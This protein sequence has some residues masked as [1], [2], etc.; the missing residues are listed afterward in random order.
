MALLWVPFRN[1]RSDVIVALALVVVM[2]ASGARRRRAAVIGA[3]AGAAIAF[4]FFDTE[5]YERFAMVKQSDVATAIALVVVGLL[6]GE[7][8]I[9]LARSRQIEGAATVDLGRVREAA[10]LLASGAEVA[11]FIG[12]VAANL[13]AVLDAD[14][15]AF[16]AEPLAATTP[17]ADRLG[18]LTPPPA[19]GP[20]TEIALPVWALGEVV[21]HFVMRAAA[22][23]TSPERLQVAMTLADQVGAALAAQAPMPPLPPAASPL[24]GGPGVLGPRLRV[25]HDAG[26][27]GGVD[28]AAPL[29][30]LEEFPQRVQHG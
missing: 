27:S 1:G 18:H 9:R 29:D 21:G 15:C 26:A 2:T 12:Q 28:A 23:D 4:T 8:A 3:T 10:A 13:E 22:A 5:P 16:S 17:V 24:P 6:T 19:A 7:L 14:S 11:D 30:R 25:V 20:P